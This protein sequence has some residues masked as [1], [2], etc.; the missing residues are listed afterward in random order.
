MIMI[1]GIAG[2]AGSGKSSVAKYLA[3]K[4]NGII[5]SFAQPLKDFAVA[6]GWN[7]EK[8]ER[9]RKLLQLLGTDI[10][11][12]LIDPNIWVNHWLKRLDK[13]ETDLV[14]AD[15]CRFFNE[16]IT[17]NSFNDCGITIKLIN[18]A[19]NP[20]DQHDSEKDIPDQLF[21]FVINSS[22]TL[23]ELYKRVEQNIGRYL[24][25]GFK[26]NNQ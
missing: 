17:I 8:D 19:Y 11:R 7:G 9:G 5:L 15:D 20:E 12:N 2:K 3:E 25:N 6:L 23:D 4:Y 26:R 14:I 13:I 22:C 10:G 24:R 18:R 16:I 1:V 21:D